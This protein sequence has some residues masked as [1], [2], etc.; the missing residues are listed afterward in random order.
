MLAS[1]TGRMCKFNENEVRIMG[2]T[3]SGVKGIELDD[4]SCIGAEIVS[5]DDVVLIVTKKGYGKQTSVRE[6]RETK[7]GSKGVKGLS[8]TDK[9]GDMA[10]FKLSRPDAD[11]VIITDAGM[12]M[13]MSLDQ[14]NVLGRVTQGV[15]LI[16]LK[17]GHSVATISLVDKEKEE[18]LSTTEENQQPD[19]LGNNDSEVVNNDS[20]LE[21]LVEVAEEE[22]DNS[23]TEE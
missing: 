11:I 16:N 14:I 3:A 10:A 19:D 5:E 15:R 13:R 23:S 1:S 17:D 22:L 20:S 12:V 7:R 6:Y 21:K 4:S 8:I 18:E 9:N 2:R